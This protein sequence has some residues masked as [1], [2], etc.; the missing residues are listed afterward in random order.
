MNNLPGTYNTITSNGVLRI[1]NSIWTGNI[2][3]GTSTFIPIVESTSTTLVVKLFTDGD[4]LWCRFVDEEFLLRCEVP[5]EGESTHDILESFIQALDQIPTPSL[6][7]CNDETVIDFVFNG[8]TIGSHVL[9]Y[10][11]IVDIRAKAKNP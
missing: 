6:T 7:K 11:E 10:N 9:T 4:D 5:L 2:T 8:V 3:S 1:G